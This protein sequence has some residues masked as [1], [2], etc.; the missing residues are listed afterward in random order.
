M[1]SCNKQKGV[2]LVEV[3]IALAILMVTAMA[4]STLQVTG[5]SSARFS[6][7]HFTLE[8]LSSDML[9]MLRADTSSASAG[10]YDFDASA[11]TSAVSSDSEVAA[12]NDRIARLLPSGQGGVE[13]TADE[14]EVSI[15]W[16]EE[17]DGS[18]HRQFFLAM[19]PI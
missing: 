14:C 11:D 10:F 4:T 17:I 3:M 5:M 16:I 1:I 7:I 2:G 6:N 12:W 9:E 18:N 13:C 19:T 15:S 8:Q